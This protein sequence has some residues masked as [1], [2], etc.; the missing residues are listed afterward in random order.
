MPGMLKQSVDSFGQGQA[1]ETA[2]DLPTVREAVSGPEELL[3]EAFSLKERIRHLQTRLNMLEQQISALAR[4]KPGTKTGRLV[5]G[6]YVAV[7]QLRENV[8]WDQEKLEKLRTH[9]GDKTFSGLFKAEYKPVSMRAVNAAMLTS[10]LHDALKWA[11]TVK[12]AKPYVQY[13]VL[14]DGIETDNG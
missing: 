5:A 1:V 2:F 14:S 13:E 7:V 6:G 3:R 10:E 11:M 4:F 8:S 12:P 9:L